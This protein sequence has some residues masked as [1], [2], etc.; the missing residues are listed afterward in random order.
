MVM[1]I[2][3]RFGCHPGGS[4]AATESVMQI[5][6]RAAHAKGSIAA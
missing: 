1:G 2:S 6:I 3:F 5:G 4:R